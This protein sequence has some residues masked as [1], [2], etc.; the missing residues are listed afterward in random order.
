MSAKAYAETLRTDPD[1]WRLK[2]SED[3]HGQQKWVYL[4]PGAQREAWPQTV[5]DRYS[6]GLET[7]RHFARC[8]LT[9]GTSC[10]PESQYAHGG[11]TQWAQVLS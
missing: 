11:R 8:C 10:A 9:A 3:S 5:V 4:Q 1:G 2:V 6:Q 7:V